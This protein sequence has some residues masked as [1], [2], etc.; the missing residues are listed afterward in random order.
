MS[1]KR[2]VPFLDSAIITEGVSFDISIKFQLGTHLVLQWRSNNIPL[3]RV[4]LPR[5]EFHAAL[6]PSPSPQMFPECLRLSPAFIDAFFPRF[7]APPAIVR[8]GSGYKF[9][10]AFFSFNNEVSLFMF[11]F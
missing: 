10:Y 9:L 4:V 1:I 5:R 3:L 8:E 11:V 7:P 2:I 6:P